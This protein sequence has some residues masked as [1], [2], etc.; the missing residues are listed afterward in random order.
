MCKCEHASMSDC[1][2]NYSRYMYNVYTGE[3]DRD[4]RLRFKVTI[5]YH[6]CVFPI[7]CVKGHLI[8]C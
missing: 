3:N 8:I 2:L 5:S 6:S 1:E 7:V 4:V